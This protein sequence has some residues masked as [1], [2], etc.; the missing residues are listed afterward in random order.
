[1]IL[2]KYWVVTIDLSGDDRDLRRSNSPVNRNDIIYFSVFA[3]GRGWPWWRLLESYGELFVSFYPRYCWCASRNVAQIRIHSTWASIVCFRCAS[4]YVCR[5]ARA[6][7][8]ILGETPGEADVRACTHTLTCIFIQSR[9]PRVLR[10]GWRQ[11]AFVARS[12]C[13]CREFPRETF[14]CRT[15]KFSAGP[16]IAANGRRAAFSLW[17]SILRKPHK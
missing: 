5:H 3:R 7:I 11:K 14:S 10:G 16:T 4:V 12:T 8:L 13:L 15:T 17:G 2:G 6:S 1:M 9:T